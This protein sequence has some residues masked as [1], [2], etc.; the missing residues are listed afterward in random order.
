MMIHHPD[1]SMDEPKDANQIRAA[2]TTRVYLALRTW[3]EA[4]E[5]LWS[6][7]DEVD[8][9]EKQELLQLQA[10]ADVMSRAETIDELHELMAMPP[11]EAIAMHRPTEQVLT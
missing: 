10:L 3:L 11:E 6:R 7:Y 5:L 4:H 2:Y 9:Q 8:D 1:T